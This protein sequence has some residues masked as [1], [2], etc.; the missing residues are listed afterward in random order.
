M[1]LFILCTILN[2]TYYNLNLNGFI[3]ITHSTVLYIRLDEM[4]AYNYIQAIKI[5]Y[6]V[7]IYLLYEVSPLVHFPCKFVVITIFEGRIAASA[8]YNCHVYK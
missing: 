5:L 2:V 3:S 1:F 6:R 4:S 8:N 7:A